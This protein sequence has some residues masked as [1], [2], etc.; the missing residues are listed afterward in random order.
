MSN[1]CIRGAV[2]L[3]IRYLL[4]MQ[5]VPGLISS[6]FEMPIRFGTGLCRNL[7]RN[8]AASTL[9]EW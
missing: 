4:T 2:G 7:G 1:I 6:E 9:L 8:S 3:M 5:K